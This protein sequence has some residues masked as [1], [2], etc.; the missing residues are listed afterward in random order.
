[1]IQA[2][3]IDSVDIDRFEKAIGRRGNRL[4]NRIFRDGEIAYCRSLPRPALHFGARFAAKEACMKCLGRGVWG[5]LAFRDIET[6]RDDDG[7][8]A[9]LLHGNAKCI[10]EEK[11]G[12]VLHLSMTHTG[13]TAMALVVVERLQ[14]DHGAGPRWSL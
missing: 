14:E 1:M 5:G 12:G 7:S 10:F 4:L 8:P 11:G 6:V 3:G 9:L 2:V 13:T